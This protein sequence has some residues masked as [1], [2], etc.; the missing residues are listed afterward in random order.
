MPPLRMT[1]IH[2]DQVLEPTKRGGAG[3]PKDAA[4]NAEVC[5][6]CQKH[7]KGSCISCQNDMAHETAAVGR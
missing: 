4:D 6:F 3:L 1:C 7:R 2:C 5:R